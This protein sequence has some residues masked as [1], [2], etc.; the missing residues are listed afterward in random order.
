MHERLERL[1][2]LPTLPRVATRLMEMLNNPETS[3]GDVAQVVRQDVSLSAKILRL[4]NSAF[5]GVPRTISSISD[6]AVLLGMNV[7]GTLV[8]SLTVFDILPGGGS[9][10]DRREFWRHNLLCAALGRLL[11]GRMRGG[12]NLEDAFCAC[13]LHDIGKVV[14]DQYLVE[15]MKKVMNEFVSGNISFHQ[16]ERR[17]LDYSHDEI[18]SLLTANWNI[19][20]NITEPMVKHHDPST[21]T[22]P[23][24]QMVS[25]CHLA[26]YLS[27]ECSSDDSGVNRAPQLDPQCRRR[28][29]LSN[30][31]IEW[32]KNQCEE[33]MDKMHIYSD[34]FTSC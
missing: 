5:Y 19:P 11:A 6:A 9:E 12:P 13:L 15:D 14:M 17:V 31:D 7:I 25:V 23:L 21:A 29:R 1:T 2:N 22:E 26:D 20:D 33:E 16:A 3:V 10:F 8:L 32:V 28:L 30:E 27:Y 34:I 4:A 18:A 24:N